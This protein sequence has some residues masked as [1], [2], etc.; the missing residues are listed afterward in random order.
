M[1][2]EKRQTA[3]LF[4]FIQF[5]NDINSYIPK[6]LRV[7]KKAARHSKTKRIRKQFAKFNF[8]VARQLI[9]PSAGCSGDPTAPVLLWASMKQSLISSLYEPLILSSACCNENPTAPG[10]LWASMQ[11]SSISSL[12]ES[13]F[14]AGV[15]ARTPL[16]RNF[17]ES[18]EAKLKFMTLRAICHLTTLLR[19]VCYRSSMTFLS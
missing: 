5:S 13:F 19:L 9:L 6:Y 14:R 4:Y 10:L 3:H 18:P 15:A 16:P 8:S 12:C 7:S 17:S 11:Q 1:N 2:F